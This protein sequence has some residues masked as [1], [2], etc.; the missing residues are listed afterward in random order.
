MNLFCYDRA[1]EGMKAK[2]GYAQDNRS[3][4]SKRSERCIGIA[5][6][7]VRIPLKRHIF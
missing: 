1:I 3:M 7:W 6:S 4:N 2:C 5:W